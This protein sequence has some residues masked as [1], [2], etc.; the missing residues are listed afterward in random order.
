LLATADVSD[1]GGYTGVDDDV[2]FAG[3]FVNAQTSEDDEPS[4][5]VDFF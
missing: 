2:V 4:T 3:V 5:S 1:V